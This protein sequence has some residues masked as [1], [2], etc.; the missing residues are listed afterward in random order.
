MALDE[1]R[2]DDHV[3][4]TSGI[5]LFIDPLSSDYLK[6]SQIGYEDSPMGGGFTI[7]NPNQSAEGGCG[8]CGGGCGSSCDHDDDAK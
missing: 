2:D 6:G 3:I 7:N 4:E 1:P 8:G 5:K